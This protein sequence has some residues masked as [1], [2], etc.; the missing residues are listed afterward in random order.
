M[1]MHSKQDEELLH[2][3]SSA[4]TFQAFEIR[5][6]YWIEDKAIYFQI[7]FDLTAID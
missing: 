2:F 4:K 1:D 5:Q 6:G 7:S 3:Q